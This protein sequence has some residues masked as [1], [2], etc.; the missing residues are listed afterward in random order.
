MP[1]DDLT[2]VERYVLLTLMIKA[3]AV[4]F[5]RFTSL[6]A[7]QRERLVARGYLVVSGKPM[8]LD[9]TQRGHDRA[10]EELGAEPPRGSGTVGATLYAGLDFFRRLLE[11]SGTDPKDLF[12]LRIDVRTAT[13]VLTGPTDLADRIRKAYQV[14]APK[15]GDYIMLAELRGELRD[16]PVAEVDA[17]LIQLNRDPNVSLVPESNQKVLTE[18][19]RRSAVN[20]GNQDKH[21]LAI[22]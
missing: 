12:R 15:P 18:Q 10:V 9:L 21:L 4:P 5:A 11:H 3:T 16:V 7:G 17:A 22:R 8:V 20:I 13:A 19:E 1:Q 2:P 6:K 14:L